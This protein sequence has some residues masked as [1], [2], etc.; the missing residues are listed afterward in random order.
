MDVCNTNHRNTRPE[1]PRNHIGSP[2]T[3]RRWESLRSD[4]YRARRAISRLRS[5]QQSEE[6]G[7]RRVVCVGVGLRAGT[8]TRDAAVT[9]DL[10]KPN[11]D[12]DQSL[13]RAAG[14]ITTGKYSKIGEA[15]AANKRF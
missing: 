6:Y 12:P 10:T 9:Q 5:A 15:S 3:A 14:A 1:P 2:L 7:A 13:S 11:L 4:S 8:G